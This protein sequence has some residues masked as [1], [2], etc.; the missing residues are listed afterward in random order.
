VFLDLA[1][2]RCAD[3]CGL[4][5]LGE[6]R[7]QLYVERDLPQ[8]TFPELISRS[9]SRISCDVAGRPPSRRRLFHLQ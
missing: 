7:R 2:L 9:S 3:H 4:V 5:V 1:L 6:A 8:R